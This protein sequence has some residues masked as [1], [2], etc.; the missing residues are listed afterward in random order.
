MDAWQQLHA[1]LAANNGV[2]PGTLSVLELAR[3]QAECHR[4]LE[5]QLLGSDVGPW[6]IDDWVRLHWKRFCRWRYVEHLLGICRFQE[7]DPQMF[8][9]LR[10]HRD[11]TCDAVMEFVLDQMLYDD[12]EQVDLL[13]VAPDEV[14]RGRLVTVLG[15]LNLNA[16]RLGFSDGRAA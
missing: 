7:F 5:S 15:L 6:A 9:V 4:W 13:F 16:A 11:W 14:N 12:R 2:T 10:G 1:A 3:R 8:G